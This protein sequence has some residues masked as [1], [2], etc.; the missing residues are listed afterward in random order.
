MSEKIKVRNIKTGKE[1]EFT[2]EAWKNFKSLSQDRAL[3]EEVTSP[4]PKKSEPEAAEDEKPKR[5]RR[6]KAE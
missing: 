3:F 5:T 2:P 6:K 1:L 4:K